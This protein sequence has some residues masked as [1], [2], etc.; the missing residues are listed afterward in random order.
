M[1]DCAPLKI[2]I[3]DDH[4]VVR[5]GYRRLL[6][7]DDGVEVVAE[8]AD[9]ES[10]YRWL[11]DHHAD[12]L[13]L[14]LSMPGRGGLATLQR[15][16]HRVPALRVLVFTMHDSPALA[17][18]ALQLGANGYV[19]KSS[20]PQTLIDAVRA[21]GTGGC[22]LS[23]DVADAQHQSI[24]GEATAALPHRRLSPRE[25][26]LFLLFAGGAG[27]EQIAADRCLSVKTVA[28]YQT[29]IRHKTGLA[30]AL[31]MYRYAHRHG[32][33]HDAKQDRLQ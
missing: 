6:E 22:P 33:L 18:Q 12:I 29:T 4:A 5:S 30:N 7:L 20:P 11:S 28:N 10:A 17:A 8:F 1:P 16:R 21:I 9:G 19:T 14:D 25:F 27:V 2:A 24:A 3:A 32:L 26:D 15:L 31:E 13:I 23:A